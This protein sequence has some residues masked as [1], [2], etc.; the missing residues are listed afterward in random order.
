M[1]K[2]VCGEKRSTNVFEKCKIA[3]K[4]VKR[5]LR[6]YTGSVMF[7]QGRIVPDCRERR[8]WTKLGVFLQRRKGGRGNHPI[9]NN[10]IIVETN[11]NILLLLLLVMQT[12]VSRAQRGCRS[13]R[14]RSDGGQSAVRVAR[15]AP[16]GRSFAPHTRTRTN[17]RGGGKL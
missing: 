4:P 1:R 12:G 5:Q 17:A 3:I 9:Y 15:G 6:F 13:Q 7:R 14:E 8:R 10:I 11:N 16:D 2:S